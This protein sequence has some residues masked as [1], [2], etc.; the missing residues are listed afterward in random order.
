MQLKD[1]IISFDVETTGMIPGYHSVISIGAVAWRDGKEVGSF[2]GCM[3]EWNGSSRSEDTMLWWRKHK[4]EWM[5]IRSQQEEPKVVMNRFY[6]WCMTFPGERTLAANPAC[7]DA[8]LMWWY[9][10][11][12]CGEDAITT[13]FKRHRALDIRTLIAAVFN[14]PYS[15]A[16]RS[17]L[18][19]HWAEK[20]FIT[21]NAL[22]DARQQGYVLHHLMRANAGEE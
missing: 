2:H 13:A 7:F 3:K 5:N 19:A 8:A 22:D 17:L 4:D 6:D 20:Q 15:E 12:Y 14:V 21:H 18:P 16:E 9:F 10:H 1:T 11:T